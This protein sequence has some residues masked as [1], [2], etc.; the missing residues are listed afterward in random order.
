MKK[1]WA[2]DATQAGQPTEGSHLK[3]ESSGK[4]TKSGTNLQEDPELE[5]ETSGQKLKARTRTQKWVRGNAAKGQTRGRKREMPNQQ[6]AEGCGQGWVNSAILE[7]KKKALLWATQRVNNSLLKWNKLNLILCQNLNNSVFYFSL[8]IGPIFFA[9]F[10]SFMFSPISLLY[11]FYFY[12]CIFL[13]LMKKQLSGCSRL[14]KEN[15]FSNLIEMSVYAMV[16]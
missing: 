16:L 6:K 5:K 11:F 13:M 15:I 12:V 9:C 7:A 1:V 2:V 8:S 3:K 4:Q 10:F 14:T